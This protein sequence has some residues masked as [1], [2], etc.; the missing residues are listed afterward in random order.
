MLLYVLIFVILLLDDTLELD[1]VS[2]PQQR[3]LPSKDDGGS[4]LTFLSA[5]SW[6]LGTVYQFHA[7]Q[8]V[9]STP[10]IRDPFGRK[11][12]LQRSALQRA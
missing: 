1:G 4:A 9:S 12:L 11:D 8:L 10:R 2:P 5:A 6:Q 7:E 3:R